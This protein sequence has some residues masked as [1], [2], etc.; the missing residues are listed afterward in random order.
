VKPTRAVLL[1]QAAPATATR[2]LYAMR[3][4]APAHLITT[5]SLW[6]PAPGAIATPCCSQWPAVSRRA[7]PPI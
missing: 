7:G 6:S 4:A 5:I 2:R 3:L 1:L